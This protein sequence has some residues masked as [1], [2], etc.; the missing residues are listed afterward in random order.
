MSV[1]VR[2]SPQ[3]K[4][5]TRKVARFNAGK[6]A[7]D[8]K[9]LYTRHA[10]RLEVIAQHAGNDIQLTA[11]DL[12]ERGLNVFPILHKSKESYKNTPLYIARLHHCTSLCNHKG[13]YDITNLFS[14]DNLAVMTGRTSGNLLAIDCDS[15][16]AFNRVGEELTRRGLAFWAITGSKGG[17]YLLRLIEGEAA[18]VPA[19]KSLY[20]DVELWGNRHYVVLPPS[21]HPS[22]VL[23]QWATPEPRYH[24][25]QGEGVPAVSIRALEWL[26]VTLAKSAKRWQEPELHGLDN[27]AA[28]LSYTNR[29]TLAGIGVSEGNRNKKLFS[30]LCDMRGNGIEY[31]EAQ[32]IATEY[33]RREGLERSEA[34]DTFKSAYSKERTPAA[35]TG[36]Q[37]VREWQRAQAFAEAYDWRGKFGRKARTHKAAYLACIER[38]K[39]DGRLH[40]RATWREVGEIMQVHHNRAGDY[41]K[42]LARAGLIK[43]TGYK[44][45]S[46]YRF[47]F[48]ELLPVYTT[49]SCSGNNSE[50]P[51][52]QGEKDAFYYLGLTAWYIWKYLLTNEVKNG[53]QIVKVLGLPSSS[54]YAALERL[55]HDNVRLVSRAGDGM[56]YG[57]PKTEASLQAFALVQ[58]DGASPSQARRE[59]H[60]LDRELNATRQIARAR[61]YKMGNHEH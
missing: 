40:W 21:I 45:A 13:R 20:Q 32:Q 44:D 27:W 23:Y 6:D 57:E 42:G 34:M 7:Q 18:N 5:A 14:R 15:H 22:G 30:A 39:L 46:L 8:P 4:N 1:F 28:M 31:H 38:A 47:T 60:A 17:A 51:K 49:G 10:E 16:A 12:Y 48:S 53:A 41:L 54:V 50:L 55:Q 19:E 2:P 52:T 61:A 26:G 24:L 9:E 37:R 25:P 29:E 58:F 56:L 33:A 43:L 59:R 11:L 36:G 3:L 35:K